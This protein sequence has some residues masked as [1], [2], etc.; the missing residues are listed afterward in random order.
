M[1]NSV[2]QVPQI[3]IIPR[4][5]KEFWNHGITSYWSLLLALYIS[6][7]WKC[8]Q[9]LRHYLEKLKNINRVKPQVCFVHTVTTKHPVSTSP[10][11]FKLNTV[12][13]QLA[14]HDFLELSFQICL[15]IIGR[16]QVG[17]GIHPWKCKSLLYFQFSGNQYETASLNVRKFWRIGEKLYSVVTVNRY[18]RKLVWHVYV[19]QFHSLEFI[20]F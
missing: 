6:S 3:T 18:V 16:L 15:L 2:S 14:Q 5:I 20:L 13:M 10:S 7:M 8:N 9:L 19:E 1:A 12:W 11:W 17:T 4:E